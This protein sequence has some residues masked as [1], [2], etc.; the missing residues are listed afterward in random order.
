MKGHDDYLQRWYQPTFEDQNIQDEEGRNISKKLDQILN[1]K[2]QQRRK[3]MKHGAFSIKA[4]MKKMMRL[5]L[6]RVWKKTKKKSS[7]SEKMK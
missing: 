6:F 4:K 5:E 7:S 3:K 2:Q 1:M